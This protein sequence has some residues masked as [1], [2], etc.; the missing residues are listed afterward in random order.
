MEKKKSKRRQPV[1]VTASQAAIVLALL[2]AAQIA[3]SQGY[4]N[5]IFLASPSQ[6][7]TELLDAQGSGELFSNLLA[8]LQEVAVGYGLSA[9]LG[10]T[11]GVLFVAFPKVEA[12]F[13]PFFSAIMAVPKT[14]VMPLLVVWFG[15]GF[16]SK[17]VMVILF[18]M[19]NILFNTVS[20]AKQARAEHLKVARVF[21]ATRAQTVFK[22]LIPSALP[23]IFT[24]LRI[25]AATAITGVIF[26]EMTAAK[27]GAGFLLNEA[28][29]VL[30]TPRL[31]LII[32]VVTILS[33]LFVGLVNLAEHVLCRRW[34]KV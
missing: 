6:I 32:I 31:F 12:V 4:V 8:S 5:R 13:S 30:N 21:Q 16:E 19:F 15:I 22:V 14:A 28:Q 9:V 18:C 7:V 33:V 3:V 26:A 20:G 24:G 29:A 10:I 17:V 1:W 27:K 23:N 11:I 2:A 34:R 25:T